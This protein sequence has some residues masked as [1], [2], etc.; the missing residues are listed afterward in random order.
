M[1]LKGVRVIDLTDERGIYGAKLLA[2]LGADVVRPEPITGDP[3]RTRGPH[4]QSQPAQTSSLWHAFFASNRRFVSLDLATNDGNKQL[5]NLISHADIILLCKGAFAVN[6]ANLAAA[7]LARPD[8][9]VIDVSS[10]GTTGPWADYLAP[11]IVAG[12]LGGAASTTGDADTPPLKGFGE[13]NFMIAGAYVA[14]AALGALAHVRTT[15]D[16]LLYT[17]DAADE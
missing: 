3:L 2:D 14:I 8:L 9:I 1:A 7:K 4:T 15:G 6:E 12:A 10:F 17:S 13:M 11:D 16:C 5:Q